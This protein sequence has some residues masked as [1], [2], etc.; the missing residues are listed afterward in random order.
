ML[1][2]NSQPERTPGTDGKPTDPHQETETCMEEVEVEQENWSETCPAGKGMG[3]S[4][5]VAVAVAP[6]QLPATI[7]QLQKFILVARVK[8]DAV[9][10]LIR[11]ID[12]LPLAKEVREQKKQEAQMLASALLDAE[13]KLGELLKAIPQ[14]HVGDKHGSSGGTIPTLPAGISKQ[15]HYFQQL[16]EHPDIIEQVKAK[17]IEEDDLPTRTDVLRCIKKQGAR[18]EEGYWL[19]PREIYEPLDKEFHFEFD[20][21]PNPRP[22]NFDQRVFRLVLSLGLVDESDRNQWPEPYEVSHYGFRDS[23]GAAQPA[24]NNRRE[25]C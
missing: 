9:R 21:C 14:K 16:A 11:A 20:P 23:G 18:P 3:K 19:V 25:M 12:E 2:T 15:S 13:A 17:A 1:E 10:T 24:Q 6:N 5:A 8:L 22:E 4:M 7:G